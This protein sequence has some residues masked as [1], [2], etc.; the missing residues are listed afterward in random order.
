MTELRAELEKT[1]G[2]IRLREEQRANDEA[3]RSRIAGEMAEKA[4]KQTENEAEQELCR[5]KMAGLKLEMDARQEE[6]DALQE[7]YASL[8]T[9]LSQ[10]ETK[11]ESFKDEIFEQILDWHRGEGGNL[12][13][14]RPCR[15]NF[16]PERH[17]F[18]AKRSIRKADC[19]NLR[20]ICRHWR[21]R[22]MTERSRFAI[23]SRS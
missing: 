4:K 11:V 1:E 5:S 22:R 13:A 17:S 18:W 6:L 3:N 16:L 14:G 15:S 12:Q 10:D 21:S 20:C 7:E 23:W 2:E 19:I 8:S 9:V